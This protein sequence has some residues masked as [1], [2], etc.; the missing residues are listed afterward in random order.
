MDFIEQSEPILK[1]FWYVA[2]PT[3]LIFLLQSALTIFGAGSADTDIDVDMDTD[4][5]VGHIDS[6]M[7]L[8]TFRNF[9]NFLLGFGWGGINLYSSIDNKL[10][11]VL[12]A[13]VV[14]IIF[15]AVFFYIIQKVK[16]LEEDN[17]F[18]IYNL[19]GLTG[20]VYLRIPENM[21]GIGKVMIAQQGSTKEVEAVTLGPE[22][23]TG[24][25]I[26]VTSIHNEN[27]I[28]VAAKDRYNN[29]D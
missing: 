13:L 28:M 21:Q 2:L 11:L 8:F 29:K 25:K 22:I 9:I 6:P 18:N 14:G 7:E 12:A 5:G 3:S 24:A 23:P 15:V 4:T 16:L 27:A 20:E 19:I 1:M 17:T 26:I 10:L